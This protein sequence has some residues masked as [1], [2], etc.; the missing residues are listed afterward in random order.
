MYAQKVEGEAWK[1]ERID[2]TKVEK[3]SGVLH[4]T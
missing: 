3:M 2:P 1:G 4:L